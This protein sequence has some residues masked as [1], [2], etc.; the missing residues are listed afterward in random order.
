VIDVEYALGDQNLRPYGGEG[1]AIY[2][3]D[4]MTTNYEDD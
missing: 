3:T 4:K 2:F 1:M